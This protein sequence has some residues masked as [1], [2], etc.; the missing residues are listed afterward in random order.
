MKIDRNNPGAI[1]QQEQP[2]EQAE[3]PKAEPSAV[4]I[5]ESAQHP[6]KKDMPVEMLSPAVI[7]LMNSQTK[8][9]G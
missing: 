2:V 9:P 4:E 5:L 1:A 8:A 6:K 7:A 3:Q